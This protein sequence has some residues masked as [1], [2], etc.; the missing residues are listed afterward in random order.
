M[1]F[2]AARRFHAFAASSLSNEEEVISF[3]WYHETWSNLLG[4]R[5][6]DQSGVRGEHTPPTVRHHVSVD[7][8]LS[9]DPG[10]RFPITQLA[11]VSFLATCLPDEVDDF[12]RLLPIDLVIRPTG[13][14][15]V[16]VTHLVQSR[17]GCG[18][19]RLREAADGALAVKDVVSGEE[20][21]GVPRFEQGLSSISSVRRRMDVLAFTS[22]SLRVRVGREDF[23]IGLDRSWSS[24]AVGTDVLLTSPCLMSLNA[25][26]S[27][28]GE[29][30]IILAP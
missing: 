1:K 29:G 24:R 8:D 15:R 13:E 26:T 11:Q 4:V 9:N 5:H 3:Q 14:L 10:Q 25:C 19:G 7:V 18:G 16:E 27:S 23:L 21:P 2:W 20:F 12:Y 17:I 28:E 6:R 30:A 22:W